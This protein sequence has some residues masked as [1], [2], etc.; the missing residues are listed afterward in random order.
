MKVF[1]IDV[2]SSIDKVLR[3]ELTTNVDD[4][5]GFIEKRDINFADQNYWALLPNKTDENKPQS[6][7]LSESINILDS[8]YNTEYSISRLVFNQGWS[9]DFI[10]AYDSSF[11]NYSPASSSNGLF[12]RVYDDNQD[13]Y[14][15]QVDFLNIGNIV[16]TSE[17][18][19]TTDSLRQNV[20][21]K[22]ALTRRWI[23][24]SSNDTL[25]YADN[26]LF[27]RIPAG[28]VVFGSSLGETRGFSLPNS[29]ND[30][31]EYSSVFNPRLGFETYYGSSIQVV[32]AEPNVVKLT[33]ESQESPTVSCAQL[34]VGLVSSSITNRNH[35][36]FKENQE[37]IQT[38]IKDGATHVATGIVKKV[39]VNGS[40]HEV[41]VKITGNEAPADFIPQGFEGLVST[42]PG[43]YEY[44]A[45]SALLQGNDI[46]DNVNGT[47]C[48]CYTIKNV[49]YFSEGSPTCGIFTEITFTEGYQTGKDFSEGEQVYQFDL[50]FIPLDNANPPTNFDA[51]RVLALGTVMNWNSE[52]CTL[53]IL[54]TKNNFKSQNGWIFGRQSKV[55]YG[56]R[57]WNLNQ[58]R[59]VSETYGTEQVKEI[60]RV[61]GIFVDLD[62]HNDIN[63]ID[64]FNSTED[65]SILRRA[66][67][68]KTFEQ[69]NQTEVTEE[70]VATQ[71]YATDEG[72]IFLA[73]GKIVNYIL[74]SPVT[75]PGFLQI[76]AFQGQEES[77]FFRNKIA[78]PLAV[79]TVV[80]L[81]AVG[82]SDEYFC[83]T[84]S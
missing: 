73:K 80:K 46:I 21:V 15:Y 11:T 8:S 64:S 54:A 77:F 36:S 27:V 84:L 75:G 5:P 69:Q 10:T 66:Y 63:F 44:E 2:D 76:E 20:R 49:S 71:Q 31:S 45:I 14:V 35:G 29:L 70:R 60:E 48:A 40:V 22:R 37:V 6:L 16:T 59:Q 83:T 30:N 50:D 42:T 13:N 62:P 12:T 65:P 1:I 53:S 26:V 28:N 67:Q 74:P 4:V 51:E 34:T 19:I 56:G 39:V 43:D 24:G 33:L 17:G 9:G 79:A 32:S 41:F 68:V 78:N 25:S 3:K 81:P 18:N 52:T 55:R 47:I 82:E 23:P 7:P 61:K 72:N 38:Y 57:G 58:S